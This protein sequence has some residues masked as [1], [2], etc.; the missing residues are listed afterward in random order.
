MPGQVAGAI[1]LNHAGHASQRC[2]GCA[3]RACI[4]AC[5][6]PRH[7]IGLLPDGGLEHLRDPNRPGPTSLHLLAGRSLQGILD[8][9]ES[10]VRRLAGPGE[11]NND[12]GQ[13]IVRSYSYRGGGG[14]SNACS[15]TIFSC[16]INLLRLAT[17]RLSET[18]DPQA[19]PAVSTQRTSTLPSG[20]TTTLI[21]SEPTRPDFGTSA[22]A[23]LG[24]T[25]SV[26]GFRTP[27]SKCLRCTPAGI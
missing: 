1:W 19:L 9:R 17:P 3:S 16:P 20:L 15:A 2:R 5:T 27:D 11:R 12:E 8:G 6:Q 23:P 26:P 25:I 13:V 24:Q 21:A 7:V 18:A 10:L 14:M 22:P 4:G